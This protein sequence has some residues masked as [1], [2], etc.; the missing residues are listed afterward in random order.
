MQVW[1]S[2]SYFNL[3]LNKLLILIEITSN[4]LGHGTLF[5]SKV[6]FRLRVQFWETHSK[7]ENSYIKIECRNKMMYKIVD[8]SF[9]QELGN[10]WFITD[11]T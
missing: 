10:K 5:V 2:F 1:V 3:K 9:Y 6:N 11:Q 4:G 8:Q 7:N